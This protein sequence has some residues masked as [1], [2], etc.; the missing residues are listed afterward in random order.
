MKTGK[1][2]LR[3]PLKS[4]FGV[5]L[6]ALAVAVLVVCVCQS[7]AAQKTWADLQ[8]QFTTVA[9]PTGNY[10]FKAYANGVVVYLRSMDPEIADWI[11]E[12]IAQHPELVETVASP[13]LASAYISGLAVDNH[14]RNG[15]Q[16]YYEKSPGTVVRDVSGMFPGAGKY[17]A[18]YANAMFVVTLEQVGEPSDYWMSITNS[19][20]EQVQCPVSAGVTLYGHIDRVLGLEEGFEDPTGQTIEL[21]LTVDTLETFENMALTVGEQYVVY[22]MR[23]YWPPAPTEE[24]VELCIHA[25][26]LKDPE[27]LDYFGTEY[28]GSMLHYLTDAEK[29]QFAQVNPEFPVPEAIYGDTGIIT[30]AVE[31]VWD[32]Q[33]QA[34]VRDPS[35]SI[36]L[37]ESKLT[38]T[39]VPAM[40]L[41]DSTILHEYDRTDASL[42][43]TREI[44]Q[45]GGTVTISWEEYK[46]RY[47]IPTIAKLDGSV[48]NFLAE[49]EDWQRALEDI[50]INCHTFPV[51]GVEKLDYI[52][53]FA[54]GLA[55]VTQGRDFT[56]EELESGARVCIISEQ[57]A[58][59]NG[60]QVGDTIEPQFYNYD[61]N[62]PYQTYVSDG[63]N[64][65]LPNAYYYNANTAFD[66][67]PVAYTVIGL[68]R[69]DDA[70]GDAT[71]NIYAFT[72]NTIFVP[73]SSVTSDM[74]YGTQGVFRTV[75]LKNGCIEAFDAIISDN[76]FEPMHGLEELREIFAYYDQGYS[77][78]AESFYN[79]QTL[80]RQVM[81]VGITVYGMILALFL[82]LYPARQ[83]KTLRTMAGLG[84]PR[85]DKIA[86]VCLSAL[87]ILL[88]GTV[89][90]AVLALVLWGPVVGRL[91]TAGNA[92]FS[93]SLDL[94]ALAAVAAAQLVLA[95]VMVLLLSIPMTRHKD[96][97]KRK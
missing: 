53:D 45:N 18:S 54:R 73:E 92:A 77:Q 48:E 94:G 64:T 67:D 15:Y 25:K 69:Q 87:G 1:Q 22:G 17:A 32:E 11:D 13:G 55:R 93:L 28:D 85:R 96:L 75:I 90:G 27:L 4:L 6:A 51:I 10:N 86:H 2:L 40:V 52:A 30:A 78:V 35:R 46:D 95:L 97:M 34:M 91:L 43:E 20:G 80:A 33:S 63:S 56:Q 83:G 29:E 76:D 50:E 74:D 16:K 58:Q 8:Y 26:A 7:L 49:N 66:G 88:P 12:K 5:L 70:W 57:T 39:A 89:L 23:Y 81:A 21:S 79:Y 61:Y 42:V 59:M 47:G 14:S 3:Q 82:L 60:L 37:Y 31:P 62:V 36:L 41:R 24:Y 72:P 44:T 84:A 9:L 71:E 65:V 19:T 68:Y 38:R